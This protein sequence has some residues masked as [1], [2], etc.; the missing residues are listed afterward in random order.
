MDMVCESRACTGCRACEKVCPKA[1]IFFGEDDKGF[2]RPVIQS[3]K[4][5][6]CRACE[7]VCVVYHQNLH[8]EKGKVYAC[9]SKD[10][11]K[12]RQSTSGGRFVYWQKLFSGQAALYMVQ[13]LMRI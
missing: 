10:K 9:W 5:I 4:C 13:H 8:P 11:K 1:A 7:R 3:E 12:R 6:D 2:K